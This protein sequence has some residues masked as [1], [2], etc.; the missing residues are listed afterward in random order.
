MYDRWAEKRLLSSA[1]KLVVECVV[2]SA[3]PAHAFKAADVDLSGTEKGD[4]LRL[5]RVTF[6]PHVRL[7]RRVPDDFVAA[8]IKN[9]KSRV[10]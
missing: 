8:V 7:S 9:N 6:P 10:G 5:D 4:A 1:Y 2:D 3:D